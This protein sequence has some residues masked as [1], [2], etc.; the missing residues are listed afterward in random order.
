[1]ERFTDLTE[2]PAR[3]GYIERLRHLGRPARLYLLHAALL[4]SSLAISGLFFNLAIGAL[5]YERTFLG[6]LNTLSIGVAA[7]LSLPL[8]WLA[9]RI[10][11]RHGLLVS[12]ALNAAGALLFALWPARAPL[13]AYSALTGIAA[14]LFQVSAPP[15]MMRDSDAESRDHLFTANAAINVGLAGLGSLVAGGLPGL[16]GRLLGAASESA[17]AYRATFLV[18]AGGLLLS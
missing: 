13:L 15:F 11:L 16:F 5:G 10:G 1:M 4:T 17:A 14:V 18:A 12:A 2:G 9:T 8:W 7:A 6:L 3:I